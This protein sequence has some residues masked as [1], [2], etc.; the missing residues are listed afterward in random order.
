MDFQLFK[1]SIDL[2]Q[3]ESSQD[4][5]RV[6]LHKEADTEF[7]NLILPPS[8]DAGREIFVYKLHILILDKEW[9]LLQM[10][11]QVYLL[12]LLICTAV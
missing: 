11:I 9:I 5:I 12:Q 10:S 7:N 2:I 1:S 3:R 4:K 8:Q 6:F